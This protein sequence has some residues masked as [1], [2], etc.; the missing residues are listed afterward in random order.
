MSHNTTDTDHN[1]RTRY[2]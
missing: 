1:Q 2:Q